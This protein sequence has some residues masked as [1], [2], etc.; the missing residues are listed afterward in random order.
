MKTKLRHARLRLVLLAAACCLGGTTASLAAGPPLR[1]LLFSGQ[2]NHD[3]KTTTPK[4]RA[5]LADSG[6]FTVDVT[7][8]PEQ[9]TAE[10]LGRYD[11]IVSDWN[12]W[13]EAKVKA[14]PPATRTAFLDFL[15]G[16]KGYV[17]IHAGS[18]SFYDWPEYQQIGGL[19][20]NLGP[21]SH[22]PPH[23]FPVAFVGDHPITRGLAPFRTTDELWLQPGR[24]PAA[25][26]VA[27]GD[28]QPLAV[29]TALGRGRG[30]ALLLGHSAEY[31]N[32]PGFQSL[33]R[34]GT[35][36][37]ATGE[38][39]LRDAGDTAGLDPDAVLR[40]VATYRFGDDRAALLALE[41]LVQAAAADPA[42]RSTL[43]TKLAA[44]L[45]AN[46]STEGQRAFL[47]GLSF[48]GSAAEVPAL[49]QALSNPDLS[50]H[51][52][53]ALERLPAPAAEAA[54]TTALGTTTGLARAT[55]LQALATRRAAS[56]VPAIAR[57]LTDPDR[58]VAAAALDALGTL[59]GTEATTALQAAENQIAPALRERWAIALL[60]GAESLRT[61]G[62]TGEAAR[63]FA[64]LAR[65]GRPPHVREAAFPA[66]VALAGESAVADVLAALAGPDPVLRRAALRALWN[67]RQPTLLEAAAARLEALS[68]EQQE[69]VLLLCGERGYSSLLPAVTQAAASQQPEVRRAAVKTLGRIGNASAVVTLA[70]LGG[71][72]SDED[73][74]A[75]VEALARL[76]GPD[77]DAA[78]RNALAGAPPAGQRTLLRALAAREDRTATP[79]LLAVSRSP[80]PAVRAEALRTLGRLA[81][82]SAC[83]PLV[84]RL[85][86]A[87]PDD[88]A[89]LEGALVDIGRRDPATVPVLVGALAGA[90]P[91]TAASLVGVLGALGGTPACAAVRRQLQ[92]DQPDVRLA[93]V[94]VLADWPDAEPLDDLATVVETAGDARTRAIAARGLNRMAPQAPARA[95]RAAEALAGALAAT[96]DAT[97]R[98]NLLAA[99][100]GIPSLPSLRAVQAQLKH[101]A[102]AAEA[103]A[104]LLGIGEVIYPWHVAEVKAALAELRTS[105]SL[106]PELAKRADALTA[107]LSQPANFALG[108]FA[109]SPDGLEK[110][111]DAHGDQA[112]IDG[113]PATYW[114]EV[115]QQKLY[116]LRVQLRQRS[117]IGCLRILG[118]SHQN[119]AP[120]DFEIRCDDRVVKT[121]TDAAYTD[122]WLTVAFPPVPCDV[123][124]LVI[125]GA[126]G[127]SPAIREL[128]LYAEPPPQ[129]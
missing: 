127:P 38:V 43:A 14:W 90:P 117:T 80:D 3:W 6:R 109:S 83:A 56:A 81:D 129:P 31:M 11:V 7:E 124:E 28:G 37:A 98:R 93:A 45:D 72:G 21:T 36:W 51:A 61:A 32:T 77:V 120:K 49:A 34:R 69:T 20:W 76:R 39:T 85:G 96:T 111:G 2:N 65:P 22:G 35:E 87:A 9:A 42:A 71:A 118:W 17:S 106:S 105:G 75:V 8:H 115:D 99:L 125:N 68:P 82:T 54:L 104:G 108:G 114:D 33:L 60:R 59:G 24:H 112:A 91:L 27:T 13:G 97:E 53:Q 47:D 18:S 58:D 94:R 12:A 102:L 26:L 4:L 122:N 29:T 63:L 44:A 74:K 78:I 41:Q 110:D 84:Q 116:R 113:N 79:D 126:H 16:G 66:Y 103:A 64:S 101:P 100:I 55:V 23:E 62:Q 86:Q 119:H 121:V 70:R 48:L 15:R 19:F 52:G 50:Y 73:L 88:R 123:V 57:L 95:A 92:S 25:T 5:I 67:T 107:R 30:F 89:L 10:T 1:V 40:R 128:E 46:A